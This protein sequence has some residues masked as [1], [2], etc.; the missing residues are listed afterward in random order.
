MAS[1]TVSTMGRA[2]FA[3]RTRA[4]RTRLP[5][6]RAG[7]A[8]RTRPFTPA[9]AVV[10]SD[11]APEDA[12]MIVLARLDDFDLDGGGN[13]LF[14]RPGRN[15]T[16]GT[17]KATLEFGWGTVLSEDSSRRAPTEVETDEVGLNLK[18]TVGDETETLTVH[19]DIAL[20]DP[21]LKPAPGDVFTRRGQTF[22]VFAVEEHSAK[23]ENMEMTVSGIRWRGLSR[24]STPAGLNPPLQWN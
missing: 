9:A 24:V 13:P 21:A 17:H 3:F 16:F 8:F 5:F 11:P 14:W 2:G 4:F 20:L 12:C 19:C 7:F 1:F 23:D 22:C 15:G 10:T 6:G 18:G